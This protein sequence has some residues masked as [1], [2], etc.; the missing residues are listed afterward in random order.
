MK[1]EMG[2]RGCEIWKVTC[3]LDTT[4]SVTGDAEAGVENVICWTRHERHGNTNPQTK[5]P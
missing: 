3:I 1:D 2:K 5:I 4:A